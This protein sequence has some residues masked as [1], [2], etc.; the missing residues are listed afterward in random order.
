MTSFNFI[1]FINETS[2]LL[3]T[4]KRQFIELEKIL[5]K[6]VTD[7][8]LISKKKYKQFMQLN[9]KKKKKKKRFSATQITREV[10]INHLAIRNL[11]CFP[12]DG[13]VTQGFGFSELD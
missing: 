12:E 10:Q 6:L 2:K 1:I 11:F 4:I 5:S 7:N 9:V 3:N 8:G 13:A